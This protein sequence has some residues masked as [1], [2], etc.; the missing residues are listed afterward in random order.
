MLT[1]NTFCIKSYLTQRLPLLRWI[2][3][4]YL[5]NAV[6]FW[7]LGSSYFHGITPLSINLI[8]HLNEVLVWFYL[9]TTLIG[10]FALLAFLPSLMPL[11]ILLIC[12]K[13]TIISYCAIICAS[14][15]MLILIVDMAVYNQYHFHLNSIIL[16][17]VFSRDMSQIFDFTV[18]EKSLLVLLVISIIV[19]ESLFAQWL[20]HFLQTTQ[21][22]LY[23]KKLAL[24]ICA[25]LFLSYNMFLLS[26]VQPT[27][28]IYQQPQA[29]PLYTSIIMK[30]MPNLSHLPDFNNLGSDMIYQPQQRV[31]QRL[32]YPL[33]PLHCELPKKPLNIVIIAIDTWRFDML[34]NAV[35]PH[36]QQFAQ[37]SWQFNN[38]WSGGNTTQPGIFSLFYGLPE[39][40]WS[41]ATQQHIHPMLIN[42]LLQQRYQLGIFASASLTL[43]AFNKNVFSGIPHLQIITQGA[44]PADRDQT[45]TQE[46]KTFITQAQL[47]HKPFFSF[48]FYDTAHSYCTE[49]PNDNKFLPIISMCNRFDL[50]PGS[51]RSL[52]LNRYKNAVSFDDNLIGQDLNALKEHHLLENTVVII[53][54]DH[55]NEFDD[56]HQ[57]YW[58]HG[59]NFTQY[60]LRTPLII[61]WPGEQPAQYNQQTS[62]YDIAPTLL[63]RV[64]GCSNSPADYSIGRVLPVKQSALPF[65]IANS[66]IDFGIVEPDR[67]TTIYSSGNVEITDKHHIMIAGVKPNM[68]ILSQTFK[69]LNQ[70]YY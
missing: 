52:Y 55:G 68:T 13:K 44:L 64:S 30:L 6:I 42:Q 37:Q 61:Y 31:N 62:H 1:D 29:F 69:L 33:H 48:L 35:T 50:N 4:F 41:S 20:W 21:K 54:A 9:M 45:I 40:Y 10:Y 25:S 47:Q 53:T 70:Y 46:F 11:T 12:N 38:H 59:S 15:A 28:I 66:Y 65:L 57:G 36:I 67:I 18:L 22:N 17:M 34:N 14:I 43:P 3:W 51:D 56:N 58:G 7:L 16:N 5:G 26:S 60:Q 49:F 2:G 8:T 32:H 63:T 19:I 23:G 39:T 24:N 27:S